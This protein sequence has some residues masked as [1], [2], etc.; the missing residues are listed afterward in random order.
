[1]AAPLI[2]KKKKKKKRGLKLLFWEEL[3][4]IFS[5][6]TVVLQVFCSYSYNHL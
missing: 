2:T 5:Q 3:D 1:M 6:G 4:Y